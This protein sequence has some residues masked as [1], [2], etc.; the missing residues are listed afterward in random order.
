MLA[1]YLA[2]AHLFGDF[3]IQ[4]RWMAESKLRDPRIRLQ[5]VLTYGIPF[6]PIA[7]L[8]AG[9]SW[10]AGSFLVWM[11]VLHFL[12]DSRR[13]HSTLGDVVQWRLDYWRDPVTVKRSWLT[14]VTERAESTMRAVDVSDD[15]ARW[16]TP[17]PWPV[18]PL[19][20]DQTLHICQLAILGGLFL[21]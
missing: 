10:R 15:V 5:H 6:W 16:P 21:T 8:A 14:Y 9:V 7:F 2:A 17:N 3:V 1:L 11:H 13:F 4:N 18:A 19:M 12:T 20:I